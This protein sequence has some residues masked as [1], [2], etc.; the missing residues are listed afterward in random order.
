MSHST[1]SPKHDRIDPLVA[2]SQNTQPTSKL[3]ENQEFTR[4]SRMNLGRRSL[5][6]KQ[7][8]NLA[9]Q[10]PPIERGGNHT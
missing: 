9:S 3:L 2:W 6:R 1:P 5:S 10:T 8:R 4:A 7:Q